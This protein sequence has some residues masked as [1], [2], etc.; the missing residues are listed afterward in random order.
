MADDAHSWSKPVLDASS[1]GGERSGAAVILHDGF[2][3]PAA[4]ARTIVQ[5][6]LDCGA[7]LSLPLHSVLD[8][9]NA[10]RNRGAQRPAIV[11]A[12][13]LVERR[14]GELV[15]VTTAL[16]TSAYV[17]E[18]RCDDCGAIHLAVFGYGEVQPA[19]YLASFHGMLS[20]AHG[21]PRPVTLALGDVTL[22]PLLPSDAPAL[23]EYLQDPA[24]TERTSYPEITPGFVDAMIARA[25]ARWADG[26]LSRWA[27]ARSD[28]DRL[29]GTCGFGEWSRVHGW[30]EL[31]FDLAPAQWGRG[32]MTRAVAAVL[33]VAFER[34]RVQRVHAYV[35]V[36][37]ARSRQVL[38]R[39]GFAH[40]GCLRSFRVCRGQRFDFDLFALLHAQWA[41]R[42]AAAPR[43]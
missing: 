24:V 20:C 6:C 35:R 16:D 9:R 37:N 19:R 31:A 4:L 39:A 21:T 29:V 10:A 12:F 23:L 33:Q 27:L 5:R 38:L 30:A 36:D 28:D 43:A 13:G 42:G 14:L 41:A 8:E 7:A 26:E 34:A 17:L 32:V 25:R 1:C 22:R 11:A 40:E 15:G 3:D 18:V 2:E